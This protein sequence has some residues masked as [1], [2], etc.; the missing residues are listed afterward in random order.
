M[1]NPPL[2][3]LENVEYMTVHGSRSYGL[4]NEDSDWDYRGFY[5]PHI[6]LLLG[7]GSDQS[8]RSYKHDNV[9][10]VAWDI[11]HFFNLAS[12]ANPN[13]L[14]T[15]YTRDSDVVQC[16]RYG[17]A[18]RRHR[19]AFLSKKVRDSFGGYAVS[20]LKKVRT[21][22]WE[23]PRTLKDAMHLMRLLYFGGQALINHELYVYQGFEP[24]SPYFNNLKAIRAGEFDRDFVISKA[25]EEL[26]RLDKSHKMSRLPDEPDHETLNRLLV[27]CLR[28]YIEEHDVHGKRRKGAGEALVL[29]GT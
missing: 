2:H 25:E 29:V 15:L 27:S 20:Q 14:E 19:Q 18:V 9:D 5:M 3:G 24:A 4:N 22:N 21:A 23:D 8:S 12:S 17:N 1:T 16:G 7:Y 26:A 6:K 10:T 11:R 13:V 28:L